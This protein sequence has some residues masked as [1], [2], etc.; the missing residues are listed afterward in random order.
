MDAESILKQIEKYELQLMV[1]GSS[2]TEIA[3][4]HILGEC[5][6]K[7]RILLLQLVDCVAQ[8]EKDYRL[9]KAARYDRLIAE[10]IK[11]SPAFDQLKVE[12]DLIEKEIAAERLRSYMKYIDSLVSAVQTQVKIQTGIAK[13]DL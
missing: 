4:P 9:S 6:V 8:A 2:G 10:G 5:I 13:N 7:I 3:P 11:K 12:P 1:K